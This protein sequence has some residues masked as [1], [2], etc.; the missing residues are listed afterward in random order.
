[1][2]DFTLDGL[3][4]LYCTKRL[5]RCTIKA[6]RNTNKPFPHLLLTGIGGTGKTA[7]ARAIGCEMDCYFT[8]VEA[9]TFKKREHLLEVLKQA[10]DEATKRHKTLM[11]FID[12]VH[13]L[14]LPLQESLYLPLTERKL[15][16]KNS[17]LVIPPFS[18][19]I[20]TTRREMLESNSFVSRFPLQWEIGRYEDVFI[21]QI[22]AKHLRENGFKFDLS[23]IQEVRKRSLGI[24]RIAVN[25]AYKIS[26]LADS[27]SS[28]NIT[29]HDVL[30]TFEM[31]KIDERGLTPIHRQYLQILL[32]RSFNYL[33]LPIGVGSISAK[34]RQ[35]EDVILGSVEPLLFELNFVM[36]T[37][38]GRII[39]QVGREHMKNF[40]KSA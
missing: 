37:P 29:L 36:P 31:E 25:L 34:M 14:S 30:Y 7:F 5:A 26:L 40:Q 28:K 38:R 19:I 6:C 35:P 3:I 2:A 21:E 1:M 8:E 11:F 13:R 16:F 27:I 39:T 9:A 33:P 24:P 22:I 4:G 15:S 32:E 10:S 12:E 23:V 17:F 18:I 20:A